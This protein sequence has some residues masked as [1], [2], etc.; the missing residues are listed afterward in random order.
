M[1]V[2]DGGRRTFFASLS[3]ALPTEKR[4][5]TRRNWNKP[6]VSAND[7]GSG[8]A[9]LMELG[10]HMKNL[11]TAVGVDF[12]FFD[13]EEYIFNNKADEYFFGSNHFA[14]TSRRNLTTTHY[15]G[16]V[17]RDMIA[18]ENPRFPV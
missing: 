15:L 17:M 11:K 3:D 7:G 9:L 18:G 8:V 6:F 4:A 14:Q 10:H 13:G 16:A 12:V 2:G 5:V 1:S